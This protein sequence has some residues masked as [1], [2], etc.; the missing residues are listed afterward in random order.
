MS[1]FSTYN[2]FGIQHFVAWNKTIIR[3]QRATNNQRYKIPRSGFLHKTNI[4]TVYQTKSALSIG[5]VMVFCF[6]FGLWFT[7]KCS[8]LHL[9]K[10]FQSILAYIFS[11]SNILYT[12]IYGRFYGLYCLI[13]DNF[14]IYTP[15][16]YLFS[17]KGKYS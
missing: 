4:S 10:V 12:C 2:S 13:G 15:R 16:F 9:L 6:A 17:S 7:A 8:T 1:S 5:H 3:I 14:V 11:S